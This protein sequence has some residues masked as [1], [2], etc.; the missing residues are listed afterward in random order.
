LARDDGEAVGTFVR[1]FQ[2][3][4]AAFTTEPLHYRKGP[5]PGAPYTLTFHQ[6]RAKVGPDN[7]LVLICGFSLERGKVVI[8]RYTYALETDDGSE[9]LAYHWHPDMGV[10][11]PH[12]HLSK[13]SRVGRKQLQTAHLPTG[14]LEP[15]DLSRLLVELR[16]RRRPG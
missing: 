3:A 8:N 10:D 6:A 15:E 13:R 11:T 14:C 16:G 7:W 5:A 12:L 9:I 4:I 1:R 2:K